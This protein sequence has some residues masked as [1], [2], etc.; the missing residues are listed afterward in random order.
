MPLLVEWC[1]ESDL[2]TQL[3]ALEALSEVIR[4]TWPRM[5]AHASF[6]W[7][8]LHHIQHHHCADAPLEVSSDAADAQQ[9]LLQHL[10]SIAKML[11]L[12][13]GSAFQAT[14]QCECHEL[15]GGNTDIM[16]HAVQSLINQHRDPE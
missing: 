8:Q 6:L 9:Q 3:K 7:S 14:L 5:P 1:R 4:H 16:L 11:Y 12:C 13:G 10:A 2:A 15:D